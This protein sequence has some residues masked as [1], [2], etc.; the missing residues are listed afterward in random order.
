MKPASRGELPPGDASTV[1]ALAPDRLGSATVAA[2]GIAALLA[3]RVLPIL[4]RQGID[5]VPPCP[6]R[7]V[8]GHPCPFCGT[9]RSLCAMANGD[10]AGAARLHPLGPLMFT[11]LIALTVVALV[12]AVRGEGLAIRLSARQRRALLAIGV[13][14]LAV[15]WA[16]KW[17]WLGP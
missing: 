17:F 10:V 2:A 11:G 16:L 8:T 15:G 1:I 9:T 4:W 14:L 12:A 3:A 6:F 13:P 5:P 7:L